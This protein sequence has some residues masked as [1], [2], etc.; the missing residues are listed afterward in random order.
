MSNRLAHETS[1]YLLQHAENPVAWYP[2]GEEAFQKAR[3]EDKPVFLSIGYSACHWCHVMAHESF[4]DETTAGI[5][6]RGFVS[7]KVDREERPDIDNVYMAAAQAMTGSGGW[8]LSVFLTPE[9]KPF[10]AGT[11]FPKTARYGMPGFRD[12][13]NAIDD[14]WKHDRENL[15]R[16]AETLTNAFAAR[17]NRMPAV[18]TERLVERGAAG[19][20]NSFDR[21]CGGFGHAPKF[22]AP[23]NLLFLLQRYEKTGDEHALHIAV[24]TLERMH[25]GGMFDHI[26]GG[27]CRYS[28][29]RS[30]L[31]PHFEKMLYDNALLILAYSKAFEL[32]GEQRFLK[33]AERTAAYLLREM[34]SEDG[35]FFASQDADSEGQEGRYY[36]FSPQETVAVLGEKVGKAFNAC[37]DITEAGNFAGKSIPNRLKH[38]EQTDRFDAEK[39]VLLAYRRGRACLTTDEKTLTFWNALAAAAFCALYRVSG[40]EEYLLT[41]LQT[42]AF[43]ERNA[44]RGEALFASVKDG[45]TGSRAFLDDRAGLAAMKLALYGAT[46]DRAYL[47]A[48]AE[49]AKI[50]VREYFDPADGGFFFSGEHNEALL[51]RFKDASDGALPSGNSIMA[52][53][54]TRLSVLAPD[55]V[56]AEVTEQ[57]FAYMKTQAALAPSAHTAFL[58]ALSDREQPPCRIVAVGAEDP[59]RIPLLAPLGSNVI[60]LDA[61]TAEYPLA[62]G[63]QTFYVCRGFTCFPPTDTLSKAQL[64]PRR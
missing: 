35:G 31:V 3:D 16:S 56:S 37:F 46:L 24:F 50:A 61:Q 14:A 4:E 28:T 20:V 54:L 43:L 41:A 13:L 59:R 21:I 25:A 2:W 1:P 48:A 42:D 33:I 57:H 22:P 11:Y 27:F 49:H 55:A 40:K 6:N 23:H 12:L 47:D 60:V 29:D 58:A 19:L 30:F 17:N 44:I 32:T 62:N 36:L 15:I 10:Y 52:Y 9:K 39:Q 51:F 38:P 26:G 64:G 45:K 34:R 53:V 63:R 18:E 8:P 5:L 7:I